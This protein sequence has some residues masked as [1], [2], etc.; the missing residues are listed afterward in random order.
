MRRFL[1]DYDKMSVPIGCGQG[2]L[3]QC[4]EN[5]SLIEGSTAVRQ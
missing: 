1:P 4:R 5:S 2:W 3:D